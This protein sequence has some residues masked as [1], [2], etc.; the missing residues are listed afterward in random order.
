MQVRSLSLTPNLPQASVHLEALL[1]TLGLSDV[2]THNRIVCVRTMRNEFMTHRTLPL[3]SKGRWQYENFPW[4]VKRMEACVMV[5]RPV[6]AT[7]YLMC[8]SDRRRGGA[9]YLGE[10]RS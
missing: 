8:Y 9:T 6:K 1:Y 3:G 10:R 4:V 7:Q 2:P 5:L